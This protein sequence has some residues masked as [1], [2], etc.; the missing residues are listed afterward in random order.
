MDMK[1]LGPNTFGLMKKSRKYVKVA[2][3]GLKELV[4]FGKFVEIE[5]TPVVEDQKDQENELTEK[6]IEDFIHQSISNPE[7]DAAVTP[8]VVTERESDT[9]VQSSISTPEQIDALIAKFQRIA[10]KPLQT[11][12]VATEPPSESDPEDSTYS[13]LPRK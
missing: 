5:D 7:K 13:L 12:P 2:Y 8:P 1:A 9:M 4:M 3:Q 10:R 6:E 11:V